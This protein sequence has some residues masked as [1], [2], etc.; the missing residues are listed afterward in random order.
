MQKHETAKLNS[1]KGKSVHFMKKKS[2]VRLT[3]GLGLAFSY[4]SH[5][6]SFSNEVIRLPEPRPR[7]N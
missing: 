4:R 1:K 3:L 7:I 6:R 5:A 2:S